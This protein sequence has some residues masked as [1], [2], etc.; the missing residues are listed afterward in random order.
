[1]RAALKASMREHSDE[2]KVF[3]WKDCYVYRRTTSP[4][5]KHLSCFQHWSAVRLLHWNDCVFKLD[6]DG[7]GTRT[8]HPNQARG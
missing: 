7:E 2:K 5:S 6:D 4:S 8:R 1:V 3:G